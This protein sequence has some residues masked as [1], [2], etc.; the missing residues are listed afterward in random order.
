MIVFPQA[1]INLGLNVIQKRD[2]GFHNIETVF[3]PIELTDILE[4]VETEKEGVNFSNSGI[5]IGDNPNNLCVKAYR[6]LQKLFDLPSIE[7]HLNKIIPIGA[8]LGGGSADGAFMMKALNEYFKLGLSLDQMAELVVQLGSDC[9]FFI[10]NEPLFAEGKGEVFSKADLDLKGWHMVLV[11]PNLFV[12]TADAYRGMVPAIPENRVLDVVKKPVELWKGLLKNDFEV[13]IF[14][15][16]PEIAKVKQLLY[17]NGAAYAAMSGSGSSVF[18][19][20]KE[21]PNIKAFDESHFI[22]DGVL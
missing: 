22:W 10:Y 13:T 11:Y 12:P 17:D 14:K 21:K 7:I 18:G 16:Y 9:P 3:Y 6:L 19:L 15:K 2:D 4:F 20:Y 5:E 8:G 1:K